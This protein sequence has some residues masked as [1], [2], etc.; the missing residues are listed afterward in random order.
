M[1]KIAIIIDGSG[2]MNEWG[3]KSLLIYIINAIKNAC[4][5]EIKC[6]IWNEQ[7]LKLEDEN[8]FKLLGKVDTN[9]LINFVSKREYND[10]SFIVLSDGSFRQNND[11]DFK[12][13]NMYPIAIGCDSDAYMLSK[14]SKS[15]KCYDCS[16]IFKILNRI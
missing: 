14:L 16:D 1:N 15:G 6:F 10:Y 4:N 2:S 3:K 9:E 12:E 11:I 5:S 8:N 7:I 13:F